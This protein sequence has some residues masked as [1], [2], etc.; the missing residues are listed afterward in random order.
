MY[1]S[2]ESRPFV[3]AET[4][5]ICLNLLKRRTQLGPTAHIDVDSKQSNVAMLLLLLL[6]L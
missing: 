3:F 6:L 1:V 5:R 4:N 2:R